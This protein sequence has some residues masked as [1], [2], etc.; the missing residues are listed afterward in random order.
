MSKRY[1]FKNPEMIIAGSALLVSLITAF[2][3]IYSAY[4]DRSYARASVWPRLELFFNYIEEEYFAWGVTNK[5]TGPA[6]IRYARLT[7]EGQ[8]IRSWPEYLTLRTGRPVQHTQS[9]IYSR[10]VS[11]GETVKALHTTDMEAAKLIVADNNLEI[12]ICYCSVYNE[13]WLIGNSSLEPKAISHCQIDE[14]LRFMQ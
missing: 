8:P 12:E 13:C 11:A 2:V 6:L 5:G 3:S 9:F 1:S 4:T 7:Y 10:V 14:A